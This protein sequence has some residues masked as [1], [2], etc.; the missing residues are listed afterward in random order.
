MYSVDLIPKE[1]IWDLKIDSMILPWITPQIISLFTT[2]IVAFHNLIASLWSISLP[3]PPTRHHTSSPRRSKQRLVPTKD[4]L[5]W[6]YSK[7]KWTIT[8]TVSQLTTN[9]T[10]QAQFFILKT[11]I[12]NHFFANL[13][14]FLS[15]QQRRNVQTNSDTHKFLKAQ[16]QNQQTVWPLFQS[17]TLKANRGFKPKI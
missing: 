6:F 4:N 12:N 5:G 3:E 10:Q 8:F 7:S 15:F 14:L 17:L 11:G 9:E 16:G 1:L 2:L 13:D